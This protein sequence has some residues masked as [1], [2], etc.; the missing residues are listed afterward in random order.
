[1]MSKFYRSMEEELARAATVDDCIK[2]LVEQQQKDGFGFPEY[3]DP[4][5]TVREFCSSYKEN[6]EARTPED[7]LAS[8]QRNL[9]EERKKADSPMVE[10]KPL[11]TT[12]LELGAYKILWRAFRRIGFP[13]TKKKGDPGAVHDGC[14]LDIQNTPEAQ[15]G[16]RIATDGAMGYVALMNPFPILENQVTIASLHHEPQELNSRHL[17]FALWLAERSREFRCSFN[18]IGAGASIPDHFHFYGFTTTLPIEQVDPSPAIHEADDLIVCPLDQSWPVIALV[19]TGE[20][21]RITS[22]LLELVSRL[23]TLQMSVNLL[24]TPGVDAARRVYVLPRHKQ[25][26]SPETGF[27]NDFGVVEMC[28]VLV[29]E[30]TGAFLAADGRGFVHAVSDVGYPN[31]EDDRTKFLYDVVGPRPA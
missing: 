21:N 5:F 12:S 24:F 18:G 16:L 17:W 31:T 10:K 25:K 4:T 2:Q 14:F 8:F 26:P 20:S 30:S 6:F 1:M 27:T 7:T 13:G 29:C 3:W 23:S 15:R 9:E 22:Y 28:G 19:V 11:P